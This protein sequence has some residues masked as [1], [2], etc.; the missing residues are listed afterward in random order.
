[1]IFMNSV[2]GV[3]AYHGHVLPSGL[4]PE[5]PPLRTHA[6]AVSHGHVLH[7]EESG[8]P[9]GICALVLHGGPGSGCSPLLRR[10]FDPA[11]F[12]VISIDQRGAGRSRP[13]GAT[14]HNRTAE[15]LEDLRTLRE[16]LEVPRWLVAGGSWG[17]TLALAYAG[18]EPQAV[19]GLLLRSVFLPTSEEIENFFQDPSG[20]APADWARFAA[21]APADQRHDMLGFLARALQQA[22][23]AGSA[24]LQRQLALAWWRWERTL[25]GGTSV[26]SAEI[27]AKPEMLDALADRYRVQSHYLVHRCWLDAPPLL[28]R[29][30]TLPQVPTLLLHSRDDR[31]CRPDGA[32]AVHERVAHSRLR[33]VDG[34][35]HDPAHPA[36]ASA[37]VAALDSYALQGHFGDGPPQ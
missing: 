15:L 12:R 23:S 11:R 16:R 25:A 36:M 26:A 34:A 24:Q 22:P 17:A 19:A 13:R 33:W 2:E 10:F 21:V 32:Q 35:G 37:M 6:L 28:D 31:V 27:D 9:A 4:Y 30:G 8:D 5:S 1:M 18:F 7:V 3:G 29:L 14:A 20:R